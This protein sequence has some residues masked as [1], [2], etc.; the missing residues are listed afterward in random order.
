MDESTDFKGCKVLIRELECTHTWL[1]AE[2]WNKLQSLSVQDCEQLTDL[3]NT[4]FIN[5]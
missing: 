1:L 4:S 2:K 3:S 5:D